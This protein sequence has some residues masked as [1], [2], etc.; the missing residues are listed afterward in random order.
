MIRQVIVFR[1]SDFSAELPGGKGNDGDESF[2]PNIASRVRKLLGDYKGDL[3]VRGVPSQ[4]WEIELSTRPPTDP[5]LM[6]ELIIS[7]VI[8]AE[9]LDAFRQAV[10]DVNNSAA[11]QGKPKPVLGVG[12]DPSLAVTDFFC[13]SNI[14]QLLFGDRNAANLLT[15]ADL[16][17]QRGLTGNGVNI[18]IIDQGFDKSRV[19]K[20]GGGLA[21]GTIRPGTT[22]RGHGVM[23][24]RNIVDAA[25]NATFYDVPLIPARIGNLRGFLSHA[26][27]VLLRLKTLIEFLRS[28]A[29]PPWNGPWVLVNA[30]SIFNRSAVEAPIGDY[31]EN[32]HHPLNE[33]IEAI[34]DGAIDVVFAAG[35]CGQFCPDRRCGKID[36]GPGTSIF[37]ANSHRRVVTVGAVRADARWMGSSSQGPGQHRL[38]RWKPDICAPSYF[39]EA[40]DAFTGNTDGSFVYNNTGSP[41]IANTGT[42]AACAVTAGIIGAIRSGW[43]QGSLTPDDLRG[44]LNSSARQTEGSGWNGQLG[45]GIIN[46]ADTLCALDSSACRSA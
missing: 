44:V 39:R 5:P 38:S 2:F 27:H 37:G 33:V 11:E 12:A 32:P 24:V 13:P 4:N 10:E 17:K 14:D 20:F 45:N 8:P 43:D 9:E 21:N 34:V 30:W 1:R 7:L 35:N 36:L 23:I 18:V 41:Y 25:P 40:A 28:T 3:Q 46:V 31:T 16:L 19:L 29:I 42:S 6:E 15:G 22:T 26:L